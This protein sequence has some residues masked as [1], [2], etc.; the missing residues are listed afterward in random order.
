MRWLRVLVKQDKFQTSELV[1]AA[2][3]VT[4]ADVQQI[5]PQLRD[6]VA[7]EVLVSERHA[8]CSALSNNV[9]TNVCMQLQTRHVE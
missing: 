7:F 5:I 1:A 8:H 2:E 3:A 4:L 6:A 9:I